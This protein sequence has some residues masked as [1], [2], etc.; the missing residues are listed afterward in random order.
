[1]LIVDA[2]ETVDVDEHDRQLLTTAL[3]LRHALLHAI[4]EQEAIRQIG[5]RVEVRI[6]LKHALVLLV[7]G[8]IREQ[9]EILGRFA[10][11]VT[12]GTD[13]QQFGEQFAV[14]APVPHFAAP[15]A[16][17][18]HAAPHGAVE[19]VVMQTRV[20]KARVGADHF[21]APVAGDRAKSVVHIDDCRVRI[22][23]Q[24]AFAR[25]GEHTGRKAQ[26]LLCTLP[27]GDIARNAE[28]ADD[29]SFL[30]AQ[31]HLGRRHP[32]IGLVEPGFTLLDIKRLAGTD[33]LEFVGPRLLRV[34]RREEVEVRLAHGLDRI[35]QAEQRRL[36]A[37]DADDGAAP[38]LKVDVIRDVVHQGL[39]QEA[40]LSE[41]LTLVVEFLGFLVKQQLGLE[42]RR[43]FAPHQLLQLGD[44]VLPAFLGRHSTPH[45]ILGRIWIVPLQIFTVEIVWHSGRKK[46]GSIDPRPFKR[47]EDLITT[48]TSTACPFPTDC[49]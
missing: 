2:L 6:V 22:R 15:V 4:S 34:R 29:R 42:P 3:T 8:D 11:I 36:R 12:H 26:L 49:A 14:L 10:F 39:Q 7:R 32:G 20:E 38:V 46:A 5:Q 16:L 19:R 21:L 31:R 41:R 33:D 23:D 48:A 17:F 43:T 44:F 45:P 25:M 9:A 28:G 1:M 35:A 30:I 24:D 37:T 47:E 40:L 27:L 18:D 13:R